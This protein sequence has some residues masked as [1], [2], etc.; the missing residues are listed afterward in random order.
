[1]LQK[2]KQVQIHEDE[3]F[4]NDCLDRVHC[5]ENLSALIKTYT[6]P[7]VLSISGSWGSGKTTFVKMWQAQLEKEG[8][9]CIYFNAWENDFA[10]DP[11]V[12]CVAELQSHLGEDQL[13]SNNQ[14]LAKAFSIL[15]SHGKKLL[16]RGVPLGIRLGTQGALDGHQLDELI[17]VDGAADAVADAAQSMAGD[18]FDAFSKSKTALVSFRESLQKLVAG[19]A[20]SG[21]SKRPLVFFIDELDRC[22][23]TFAVEFLE[24]IKHAFNVKNLV[25]VLS[26]DRQQLCHSVRA[27]YGEGTD[28]DGYLRRFF[29][30]DFT[31]P[32]PDRGV[33]WARLIE[34]FEVPAAFSE[35]HLGNRRFDDLVRILICF[36]EAFDL[37]LRTMEQIATQV[38]IGIKSLWP[39]A[40][41]DTVLFA[42]LV[43]LRAHRPELFDDYVGGRC[44]AEQLIREIRDLPG[45]ADFLT[46]H[47]GIT[48]E[49]WLNLCSRAGSETENFRRE[50]QKAPA[51]SREFQMFQMCQALVEVDYQYKV[52]L[53]LINVTGQWISDAARENRTQG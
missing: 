8:H 29:D 43:T 5:A 10:D 11:L 17:G 52:T 51:E 38:R 39:I 20:Q 22:R 2:A 25:F 27:L 7:F 9:K 50:I 31:L 28:A 18:H 33:F 41:V 14:K 16:R 30:L 19:V 53:G 35:R 37:S 15:K 42:F 12:A 24:R 23:P 40:K 48:L 46:K 34:E 45:V 21:D 1:M 6:E 36:S 47:T 49:V 3:P 26:V 32:D 4:K 44:S 13:L